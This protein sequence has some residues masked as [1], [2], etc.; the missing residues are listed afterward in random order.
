MR[1]LVG[2]LLL[3]VG[4]A[5]IGAGSAQHPGSGSGGWWEWLS[6]SIGS[7]SFVLQLGGGALGVFGLMLLLIT[8]HR[9]EE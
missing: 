8:P 7:G 4:L 1:I 3:V 9:R 2:L 5:L 6:G